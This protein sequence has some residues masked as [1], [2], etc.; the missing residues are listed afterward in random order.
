MGERIPD[1]GTNIH[2]QAIVDPNA[3][4]GENV[5]IEAFSIVGPKARVGDGCHIH[6]HATV[7]GRVILGK[8]NTVYP[9]ALI[10]GLTHDLKYQGGE[11]GLMIGAENIFREYVTAHV[12][13]NPDDETVI[14]SGNVFLAYSHVAHDCIVGDNLVMSSHSALGGHVRVDDSVNIGWGSGVHQFCR[15]GRYCMVSACS[16]LVQDVAPFMLADGSP[17]E[18]RS[19]NKVGMERA[20]F[21]SEDVE[22]ARGVFKV[23][24][25]SNF[26]RSQ[27]I[28]YLRNEFSK[29]NKAVSEEIIE[30]AQSSERGLA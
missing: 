24:Y 7:E 12:A 19:I 4:L 3:E 22:T 9:Y 2:S 6:H 25:K 15:L 5:S 20:G 28:D 14:G 23:L 18:V 21:S 27:A 13:T 11:P 30:F 1:M 17:A 29:G 10:G 16:K 26:N 8:N